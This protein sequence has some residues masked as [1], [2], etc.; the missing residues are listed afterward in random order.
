[1]SSILREAPRYEIQLIHIQGS[2][3]GEIS[4]FVTDQVT[5]GRQQNCSVKFPPAEEGVSRNHATIQR[6][7]NQFRLIDTSTYGTF[8]NGKRAGEATFLRSGD[9]LEIGPGGPKV[10]FHA[11]ITEETSANANKP[12]ALV[13]QADPVRPQVSARTVH[14]EPL[15]D[16]ATETP[17]Q[18]QP[19]PIQPTTPIQARAVLPV[20][21][22]KAPL[23]IQFGPIIKSYNELP[24]VIGSDAGADFVLQY[25]G[26]STRHLQLFYSC[27]EYWVKN[28]AGACIV[29]VNQKKMDSEVQLKPFDE[30]ECCPGGPT[31]RYIGEG[32]LVEVEQNPSSSWPA[33]EAHSSAFQDNPLPKMEEGGFFSKF[34]KGFK[35]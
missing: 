24:V 27:G 6:E 32:R 30:I 7:G 13:P 4:T 17:P 15:R 28:L 8:V 14:D 9:V 2:L 12:P 1:M 23:V 3:K 5:I 22:T 19:Q 11:E 33:Q 31:F 21:K 34:V 20:E 25:P 26:I 18:R 10:S 16:P 35:K 29:A